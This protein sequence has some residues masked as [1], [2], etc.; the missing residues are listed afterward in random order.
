V[1]SLLRR[2]IDGRRSMS[3]CSDAALRRA[4]SAARR[5]SPS[6]GLGRLDEVSPRGGIDSGHRGDLTGLGGG[7]VTLG[8][9]PRQGQATTLLLSQSRE[10]RSTPRPARWSQRRATRP[11]C[12]ARHLYA[13]PPRHN[14]G[15]KRLAGRGQ[16][17][18]LGEV[19]DRRC[20][21]L[22]GHVL[23]LECSDLGLEPDED[24]ISR[25]QQGTSSCKRRGQQRLGAG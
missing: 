1:R 8:A 4:I 23:W 13:R 22:E 7:E 21:R 19:P 10:C 18:D 15:P 20:S 24:L 11:G 3:D 6:D 12:G 25:G 2:R 16:A 17:L 14:D 9:V 5:N